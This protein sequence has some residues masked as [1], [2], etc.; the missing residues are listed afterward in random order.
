MNTNDIIMKECASYEKCSAP[1]C[2]LD[3]DK[4]K[5]VSFSDDEKCI[6]SKRTRM[7]IGRKYKLMNQGLSGREVCGIL[8]LYKTLDDYYDYKFKTANKPK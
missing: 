8:K 7:N 1:L 4:E 3:I 2:P 6:A 5:R